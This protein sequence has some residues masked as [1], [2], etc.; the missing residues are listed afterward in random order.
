MKKYILIEGDYNDGD[1]D[2]CMTRVTDDEINLIRPVVAAIKKN[3]G[4]YCN[5]E[6]AEKHHSAKLSYGHLEGFEIFDECTPRGE[7]N[8]HGIHTIESV[9][10]ITILEQLL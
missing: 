1:Y 9:K 5:R 6:M 3:D 4:D 2:M 10:I 7:S 8:C